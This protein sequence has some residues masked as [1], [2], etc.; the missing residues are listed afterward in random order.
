MLVP[1]AI[2][3]RGNIFGTFGNRVSTTI[4][5]GTFRLSGRRD[6]ILGQNILA[7]M[8]LTVQRIG[9][10]RRARQSHHRDRRCQAPHA[11]SLADLTAISIIGGGAPVDRRARDLT[12]AVPAGAERNGWDLDNVAA[13][14][15]TA[16][17]DVVTLPALFLGTYLVG[18]S[19]V[20]PAST[21]SLARCSP[22]RR[23]IV[24][25]RAKLPVLRRIARESIPILLIAGVID[26]VAGVTIEKRLESFVA[27]PAL[28]VLGRTVPSKTRGRWAASCQPPVDPS[29]PRHARRQALQPDPAGPARRELT[30]V[31]SP[32]RSSC[33]SG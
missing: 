21:A 27:F 7:S 1:A 2:G 14:I 6:T 16:L 20:T 29:A 33:C 4:H 24:S 30:N 12:L 5:A 10:R 31:P 28:L 32:S 26:V 22:A 13:P 11:I 19:W 15:V 9:R 17:G 23:A 25:V 3:L 8:V 18:I